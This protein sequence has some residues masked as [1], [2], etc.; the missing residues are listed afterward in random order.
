MELEGSLRW[1]QKGKR[2]R[3]CGFG[4]VFCW[5]YASFMGFFCW[6]YGGY[7]VVCFFYRL[8][9]YFDISIVDGL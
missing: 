6:F 7:M 9:V 2:D 5:F 8:E 1:L 3:F 4:L